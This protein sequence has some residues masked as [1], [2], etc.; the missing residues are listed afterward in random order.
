MILN[1]SDYKITPA[2][3]SAQLTKGFQEAIDTLPD[4]GGVVVVS[5]GDWSALDP[6]SLTVPLVNIGTGRNQRKDVTWIAYGS[7]LPRKMPGMVIRSGQHREWGYDADKGIDAGRFG[8]ALLHLRAEQMNPQGQNQQD[9]IVHIQGYVPSATSGLDSESIGYKFDMVSEAADENAAL[10]GIRG[11]VTGQGGAAKLR[12][13]RLYGVGK[14]GH[15]GVLTG[16][17]SGIER[18]GVI[19]AVYGGNGV[20]QW[21]QNSTANYGSNIDYAFVGQTG[22]GIRGA[23]LAQ[24]FNDDGDTPQSAFAMGF[25][26]QAIK[27]SQAA[28]LLHA[29]GAG[30]VIRVLDDENGVNKIAELSKNGTMNAKSFRS[31]DSAISVADDAVA[32]INPP[33]NSGILKF[34]VVNAVNFFGEVY[35]RVSDGA[36]NLGYKGSATDILPSTVPTGATGVDGRL[37]VAAG[38]GNLYIE[39]RTG[40]ARAIGIAFF[41]A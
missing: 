37:T 23:F 40:G 30:A 15:A 21:T 35:Y 20:L 6:A 29:G 3:S 22:A 4:A 8:D 17:M 19:P 14:D 28:V 39:N 12:A 32:T 33:H 25:G 10:R 13:M 24:G 18:V 16:I 34:W 38:G 27:P 11:T 7:T 2:S 41:S 31:T 1:L 5:P 9:A 36:L 26:N